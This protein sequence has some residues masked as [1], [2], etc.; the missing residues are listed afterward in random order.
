M[1][2]RILAFA[3]AR[4]S[5]GLAEFEFPLE[6]GADLDTLQRALS[7][8]HPSLVGQWERIAIAIDG[9]I[10]RGNPTLTAGQEIALLPPVSGG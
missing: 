1:E 5:I 7:S 6:D 3:S 9:H 4:E 8:V 2:V 10:E